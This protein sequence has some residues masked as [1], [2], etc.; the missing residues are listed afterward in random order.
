M[1]IFNSLGSNYSLS[2]VRAALF[3]PNTN[4]YKKDLKEYLEKKYRGKATLVYK[5]REALE[6]ALESANLPKDSKVGVTAFTCYAV[7]KAVKNAGH[8][9]V[10]L[11]I[12]ESLNFTINSIPKDLKAIIVQNTLGF[13]CAI[14]KIIE[15]C[16][17][18]NCLII[19]DLAHCVGAMYE[20]GKEAG[21]V[22][23][24]T[25]LSF[26]QDKMIDAVSGGALI[27]R[28]KK[29]Q[30]E[31]IILSAVNSTTQLKDR[32]YSFLTFIIRGTYVL[33]I[34][35]ALH[36]LSKK[37]N[38]LS[39]PIEEDKGLKNLPYW[40]CKL[41]KTAFNDLN[42]NLQHRRKI[43]SIYAE[44]INKEFLSASIIRI[45]E[46]SSN[47][48]FSIFVNNRDDLIKYLKK[49]RIY[50]SDI[51]YDAPIGPKKYLKR[52]DYQKGLC[53]NAEHIAATIVNLPTHINISEKQA[54][55]ISQKINEWYKQEK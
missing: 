36:F 32:I 37:L 25:V 53:P 40:Y 47:L 9:V 18:N 28:N 27:I 4:L 24:F 19:E 31:S 16:S 14:E 6:L 33:G 5:G 21:T 49:C 46:A 20:N 55:Y 17:E 45:I 10:Y 34:G 29:Y 8:K 12:D 43:A 26:S 41:V 51:W 2:F 52:T 38:L 15:F 50:I 35:K 13:P 22:G 30:K 54:L 23:D 1:S 39:L 42:N 44:N 7:W 3:T 11:D 48:R